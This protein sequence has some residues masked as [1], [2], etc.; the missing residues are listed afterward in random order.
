MKKSSVWA[1]I[2]A[3]SATTPSVALAEEVPAPAATQEAQTE[4]PSETKK[5]DWKHFRAYATAMIQS[6]G[7]FNLPLLTQ[8]GM[9]TTGGVSFN[10]EYNLN[11][12]RFKLRGHLGLTPMKE[13]TGSLFLA[14]D[15]MAL[16]DVSIL[17][18]LSLELGGGGSLWT[19]ELSVF[20]AAMAG[21]RFPKTNKWFGLI[22]AVVLDYSITFQGN[23]N[24]G[25]LRLALAIGI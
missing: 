23:T 20:P 21:L 12:Q 14:T 9:Q 4:T 8:A 7:L 13:G 22:E 10:P 16:M 25:G 17:S 18:W 5:F 15:F 3:L 24:T 11:S 2:L 6:P 19:D 1:V